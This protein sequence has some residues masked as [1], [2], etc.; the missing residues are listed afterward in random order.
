MTASARLIRML[1]SAEATF[2]RRFG[3]MGDGNLHLV[4]A[5]R[6]I[7][8]MRYVAARHESGAVCM[9]NGYARAASSVGIAACPCATSPVAI[10]TTSR[11]ARKIAMKRKSFE[12]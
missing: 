3:V 7:P 9:A 11:I 2:E 4:S 10:S 12:R 1:P 8:G 6:G 5:Y